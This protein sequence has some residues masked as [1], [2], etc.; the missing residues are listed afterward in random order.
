MVAILIKVLHFYQ[1][2]D[3]QTLELTDDKI[4][5]SKENGIQRLV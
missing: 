2:N 1:L 5:S 3:L 4:V